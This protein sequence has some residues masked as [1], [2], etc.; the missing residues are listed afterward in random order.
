LLRRASVES[1]AWPVTPSAA[2]PG[3]LGAAGLSRL[4]A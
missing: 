3:R 4:T 2:P 1:A